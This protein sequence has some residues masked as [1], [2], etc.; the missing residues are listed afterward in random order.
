MLRKVDQCGALSI[1]VGRGLAK[2]RQARWNTSVRIHGP[3]SPSCV[4]SCWFVGAASS[5]QANLALQTQ[6]RKKG[7]PLMERVPT[8]TNIAMV[9]PASETPCRRRQHCL[10]HR[11]VV[12]PLRNQ[13]VDDAVTTLS[14]H[15]TS[16]VTLPRLPRNST[17]DQPDH[18]RWGQANQTHDLIAVRSEEVPPGNR[19]GDQPAQP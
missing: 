19:A 3:D 13:A 9:N 12:K 10:E 2:I 11:S 17:G 7:A 14:L 18:R 5:L 6:Q 15:A 8:V 16:S 4:F 1:Q